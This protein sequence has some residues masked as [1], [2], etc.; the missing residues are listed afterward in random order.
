MKLAIFAATAFTTCLAFSAAP[1]HAANEH[2]WVASNGSGSTCTRAAPCEDFSTAIFNTNAGGIISCVDGGEY[3][4]ISATKS[5]TIDCRGTNARAN[6]LNVGTA[7]ITVTVKGVAFQYLTGSATG[8][9]IFA[10]ATVII[11]DCTADTY[12]AAGGG[13]G[14]G[15]HVKPT[16]SG[17]SKLTL[18]DV[19][20]AANALNGIYI[21]GTA[22]SSPIHVNVSN[23]LIASN[24]GS[25]IATNASAT[26]EIRLMMDGVEVAANG[27]GVNS[28]GPLSNVIIGRSTV[29]EN[30]VGFATSGGGKIYS[31]GTN[32]INGNNNDNVNVSTLIS[33]N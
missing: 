20:L 13:S 3:G 15:V 31:Y 9:F 19:K 30:Q 16:G 6:V 11:E 21:D 32:Q 12:I 33:Q 27:I 1:A 7:G 4:G 24:T 23:S 18:R 25:G 22:S 5:L 29:T 2:S 28:N 8:I 26:A 10:H 17:I 14:N